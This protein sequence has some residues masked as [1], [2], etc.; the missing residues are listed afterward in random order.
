[1][2]WLLD[3]CV[4]SELT[5]KAPDAAVLQWLAAHA[6]NAALT[7]VTVGELQ[8]GIES[9]MPWFGEL[10]VLPG[11]KTTEEDDPPMAAAIAASNHQHPDH[12]TSVWPPPDRPTN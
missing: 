2:Q 10:P 7:V 12:D 11:D 8:Y 9:R 6:A 1:M 4:L 5:R 3:T